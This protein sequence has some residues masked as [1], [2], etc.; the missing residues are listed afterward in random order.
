M[1]VAFSMKHPHK[2]GDTVKII[3]PEY[4]AQLYHTKIGKCVLSS[5]PVILHNA[6]S[7]IWHIQC[8]I[9]KYMY[10]TFYKLNV[11]A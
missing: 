8:S 10:H 5:N 9:N 4:A 2:L 11:A 6:A 3:T 7:N 1:Y